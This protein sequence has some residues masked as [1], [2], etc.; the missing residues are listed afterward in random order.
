[1]AY[2]QVQAQQQNF[3]GAASAFAE[4]IRLSEPRAELYE[5][6]GESLFLTGNGQA[7]EDVFFALRKAIELDPTRERARYILAEWLY[8]NGRPEDGLRMMVDLLEETK[9]PDFRLHLDQRI[10]DAI[11]QLTKAIEE[12][13]D[14]P[15][16]SS[17]PSPPAPTAAQQSDGLAGLTPEQRA[18]VEGMVASLAARLDEEP[19]DLEG[20]LRLIRSYS[21][22]GDNKSAKAAV[23]KATFTF[24]TNPQALQQILVLVEELQIV[25]GPQLPEAA[26]QLQGQD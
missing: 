10:Q 25:S 23:D 14:V 11:A 19:N 1:M 2:G 24:L 16:N 15:E 13:E 12:G 5:M 3:G 17:Q 9:D 6:Y 21:V 22:M 7:S 26:K 18:Q 4:A 20:W 8:M